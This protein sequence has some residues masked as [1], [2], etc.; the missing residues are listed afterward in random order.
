MKI[1]S[2]HNI[3]FSKILHACHAYK[4]LQNEYRKPCLIDPFFLQ[5]FNNIDYKYFVTYLL[6]KSYVMYEVDDK[7]LLW[8]AYTEAHERKNGYITMLL[9]H[10][11]EQFN[12]K[13]IVGHTYDKSL[14]KILTAL[15]ITLHGEQAGR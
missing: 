13:T 3:D 14:I 1:A 11:K 2:D 9:K 5:E 12:E 6:N 10:L 8:A 15:K 7:V 4:F